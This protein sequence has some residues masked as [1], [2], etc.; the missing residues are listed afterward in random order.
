MHKKS[1]PYLGEKSQG[2]SESQFLKASGHW[3]IGALKN[4][5]RIIGSRGMFFLLER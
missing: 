1:P 2:M 3:E 4:Y 5:N